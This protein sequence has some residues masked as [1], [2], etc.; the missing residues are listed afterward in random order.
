M[1]FT[2]RNR[3]AQGLQLPEGQVAKYAVGCLDNEA[4]KR[5]LRARGV[6]LDDAQL[7]AALEFCKGLPLAL[8]LLNRALAAENN[9]AGVIERLQTS[10]SSSYDKEE[11]L[12]SALSFSVECLSQELQS[13]WLDL[14]WM[15]LQQP[16]TL[17][18]LHCLF[19]V[20]TLQQLQNRSLI[21]LCGTGWPDD[22]VTAKP[23]LG[24]VLHDVLLRLAERMYGQQ[25]KAYCLT[26]GHTRSI[27]LSQGV[28]VCISRCVAVFCG[29]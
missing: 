24:V 6:K 7:Q 12:V 19:G 25:G 28:Q 3:A 11:E 5:V 13:A 17:L 4:S 22:V 9:P 2:S 15:Y 26:L 1:L 23:M 21:A 18:E 27:S 16:V 20:N 29:V 14:A 10:G 8:T